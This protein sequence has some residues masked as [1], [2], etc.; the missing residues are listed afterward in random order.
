MN[1]GT[2][3]RSIGKVSVVCLES[4]WFVVSSGD[5]GCDHPFL[6]YEEVTNASS[7]CYLLFLRDYIG[8]RNLWL[9]RKHAYTSHH[10]SF[11][12]LKIMRKIV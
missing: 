9:V 8:S 3:H 2:L 11:L 5:Q 12:S 4:V 10:L 6:I 7:F 1:R